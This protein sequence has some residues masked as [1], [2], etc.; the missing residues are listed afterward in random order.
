M[1][2]RFEHVVTSTH[3]PIFPEELE[4]LEED[5]WELVGMNYQGWTIE[6][7]IKRPVE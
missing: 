3:K 5:G 2:K 4:K 1:K 7:V 6:Y